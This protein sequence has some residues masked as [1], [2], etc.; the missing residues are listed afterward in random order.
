M[1]TDAYLDFLSSS[2][3]IKVLDHDRIFPNSLE[4]TIQ[5]TIHSVAS[6][7]RA[8]TVEPQKQPLLSNTRMQQ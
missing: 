6:L 4:L 5:P 8:R 3:H 1:L 7:L 2:R